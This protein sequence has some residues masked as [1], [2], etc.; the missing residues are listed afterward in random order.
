MSR[1]YRKKRTYSSKED[2]EIRKAKGNPYKSTLELKVARECLQEYLYEPV[3]S[4]VSYT[5]PHTYHPD[6][7]HPKQPNVLLECKG[8]FIK[9]SADA[10]KYVAIA[11]DNPDKELVFIFSD[12][13]KKAYAGVKMRKDG[14]YLSLAEWCFKSDLLYVTQDTIPREMLEGLW[15]VEDVRKY[16]R[17]LYGR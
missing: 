3:G 8:W 6:F 14:T 13:S 7:V 10:A 15:G 16:K 11:R 4:C 17:E 5:I 9:G 12:P 1:T 2:L